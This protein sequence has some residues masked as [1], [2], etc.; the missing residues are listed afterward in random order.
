VAV[1]S[2]NVG[3]IPDLLGDSAAALLVGPDNHEEMAARIM[4]LLSNNQLA[5][6]MAIAARGVAE[7][8][9]W[10]SVRNRLLKVYY[11]DSPFPTAAKTVE[12]E[13]L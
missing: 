10:E 3:G 6:R 5:T 8:Y 2:T 9:C 1:V 12:S 11:P 7:K 13:P 4:E